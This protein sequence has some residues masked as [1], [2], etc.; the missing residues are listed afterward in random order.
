M[1]L[2]IQLTMQELINA[3]RLMADG[4]AVGPDGVS[5]ELFQITL[6]GDIA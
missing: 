2:D 5:I 4:K 6:N 3:I 1:P